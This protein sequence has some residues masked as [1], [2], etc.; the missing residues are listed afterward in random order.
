MINTDKK[1]LGSYINAITLEKLDYADVK[2]KATLLSST[3]IHEYGLQPGDTVSLFS[4]NTIWYPV[5]M[6]A[7]IRAGGRV[8]GAS[9]AYNVEEMSHALKTAGTRFLMTLPGS[10]DAAVRACEA[11]GSVF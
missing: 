9:P 1:N 8:N 11:V 7:T 3:L 2:E 5:A 10:L 4:T 6:W